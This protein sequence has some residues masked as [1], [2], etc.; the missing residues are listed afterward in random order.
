MRQL[1]QREFASIM[2]V[3]NIQLE[4]LCVTG[5]W[6]VLCGEDGAERRGS[7]A[8][9]W[10]VLEESAR[11]QLNLLA[12]LT[13]TVIIVSVQT[14]AELTLNTQTHTPLAAIAC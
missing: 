4:Y 3:Q 8:E 2:Q 13:P 9:S 11:A 14:I 12:D 6:K 1:A 10:L 7:A 5:L